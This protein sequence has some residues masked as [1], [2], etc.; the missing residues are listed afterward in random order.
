MAGTEAEYD[1][2]LKETVHRDKS[3]LEELFQ[4]LK[5]IGEELRREHLR[6]AETDRV[7]G[8]NTGV[9]PINRMCRNCFNSCKQ[10]AEV[11]IRHC[12]RYRSIK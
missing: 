7:I 6:R 9:G 3:E 5:E 1:D 11:R 10:P 4:E 12:D 2:R 8:I